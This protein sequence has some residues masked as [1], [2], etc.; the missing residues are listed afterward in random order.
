[1]NFEVF[2]MKDEVNFHR[3]FY[4]AFYRHAVRPNK[5]LSKFEAAKLHAKAWEKYLSD[6]GVEFVLDKGETIEEPKVWLKDPHY[7]QFFLVMDQ[8]LAMRI[9]ALGLP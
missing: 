2:A 1:M 6:I 9:L 4:E 5:E 3:L 8:E 7:R